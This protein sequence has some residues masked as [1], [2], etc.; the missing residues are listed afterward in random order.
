MIEEVGDDGSSVT[1]EG[2]E[3]D[4]MLRRADT[5]DAVFGGPGAFE[6]DEETCDPMDNLSMVI[7]NLV[8]SF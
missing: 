2:T 7:S 3:A 4:L 8:G 6:A 5:L 1:S